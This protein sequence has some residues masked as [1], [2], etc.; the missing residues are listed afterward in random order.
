M[1]LSHMPEIVDTLILVTT[2]SPSSL[3]LGEITPPYIS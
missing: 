1:H 2:P 3:E